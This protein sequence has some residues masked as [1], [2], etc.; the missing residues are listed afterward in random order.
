MSNKPNI[1]GFCQAGCKWETV[2]KEDFEKSVTYVEIPINDN[3]A[4]LTKGKKYKIFDNPTATTRTLKVIYHY[5]KSFNGDYPT[6]QS[7]EF[8]LP[9]ID[10]YDKYLYFKLLAAHFG[11]TYTTD[12][13]DTQIEL[14]Y[15]INGERHSEIIK[16]TLNEDAFEPVT[17][18]A[19][20]LEVTGAYKVCV[21]NE[22][23]N[24]TL[25]SNT[26]FIMYADDENGTNMT[27]TYNNQEYLGTYVGT[28][29]STNPSDYTWMKVGYSGGSGGTENHSKLS[30]LDY[31]SSGHTG[32]AS[33]TELE[34]YAKKTE[35]PDS[36]SDSEIDDIVK[37]A[38]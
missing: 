1:Y 22:D 27:D 7:Y 19:N 18:Q 38:I 12:I 16:A 28:K 9:Y 13:Y 25:E 4:V 11:K 32:F 8:T 36:I 23:A 5:I 37:N 15:E 26:L 10:N 24:V 6:V 3:I 34:D 14:T 21:Y 20:E 17:T 30:N 29:A 2:H 31:E 33:K 35:L